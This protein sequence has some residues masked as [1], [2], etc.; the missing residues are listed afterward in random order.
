MELFTFSSTRGCRSYLIIDEASRK[1]LLIDASDE[2]GEVAYLNTL[3]EHKATLQFLVETHTHADHISIAPLLR[4]RTGAKIIR[5][6]NA[7]SRVTDIRI[8]EGVLTLGNSTLTFL[9][10]PGH[11]NEHIA[12]S[13]DGHCF[14]G[15]ALLIGGTGRTDFQLGDSEDLYHTLHHVIGR[16]PLETLIHPGHEYR[17][18]TDPTLGEELQTN[19]RLNMCESEFIRHMNDYHPPR[20]ERFE[21][22]ISAN[23]K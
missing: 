23:I 8:H 6:T 14:T 9:S 7:P 3:N 4:T 19:P 1:A 20:P 18:R 15:D 5:H 2:V 16:L 21:E 13:I 22:S 12:I 17:N 11:T 10:T